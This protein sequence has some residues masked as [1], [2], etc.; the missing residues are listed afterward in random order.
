MRKLLLIIAVLFCCQLQLQAQGYQLTVKFKQIT[1]GQMFLAHYMG[2][3]TY[4]AD[5]AIVDA[6]GTAVLKNKEALPGG[7]YLIVFPDKQRYFEMLLDKNQVFTISVDTSDLI[8]KTVYKTSP[9]NDLFLGYNRFLSSLAPKTARIQQELAAAHTAADTAKVRPLQTELNKEIQDYR[10]DFVSKHPESLL[11][12]IFR[13]MKEP[14]VPAK[15]ANEDST[16]AYR[17]FRSHYWDDVNLNDGRLVRTP[18]LEGKLQKYF[19]QLVPMEPDSIIA[20]C[21]NLIAKT[22][23][24]KEMF[25]FVLW[26]LTANFE[27]SPYMGMDAV[28]VHLV[29]KY[30]VPGDAYWV[31]GEQL[32]KIISRAYSIAPNLIGQPAPPLDM[33]DSTAKPLSLYATKAKYT[34]LVFW[35]PTCGHCKTEIPRLD[36]AYKAS[37]RKKGV[38][39]VGV[40]TDGTREEWLQFIKAHDL[41]GWVHAWDPQAQSNYRRLY[42]VYATPVVYLLDEKKKILAKRLGVEQLDGFLER[43]EQGTAANK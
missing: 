22:R 42:D 36:S 27:A 17:Y 41:K 19:T 43:L 26:W 15:P 40:K 24:D 32:N 23:K 16:F 35:D 29:E 3:K 28:F 21:D 5:S 18:I 1:G 30:Y 39:M 38:V 14:E 9:E 25:K 31:S 4:L 20:E 7:I 11:T 37:W 12:S 2:K 6:T 33:Q 8:G 13:A 10:A 34:V